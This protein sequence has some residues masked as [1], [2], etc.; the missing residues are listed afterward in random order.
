ML[1]IVLLLCSMLFASHDTHA[2]FSS[3]LEVKR[4]FCHHVHANAARSAHASAKSPGA[5]VSPSP[6]SA[7]M[8]MRALVSARRTPGGKRM[9]VRSDIR[10]LSFILIA[11]KMGF[12]LEDIRT[13]LRQLPLERTPT[14]SATGRRSA[15]GFRTHLDQRIAMLERLQRPA[16]RLHRLRLP[17]A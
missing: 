6:Q 1:A 12:S 3:E 11:Q 4:F 17:V 5:P 8:T 2:T 15:G 9:F 10:R 14:T 16:R 7:I 13:Q